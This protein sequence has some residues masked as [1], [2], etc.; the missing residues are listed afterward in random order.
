MDEIPADHII[1][2]GEQRNGLGLG[3]KG[4]RKLAFD[5]AEKYRIPHIFNKEKLLI[6]KQ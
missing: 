6:R 1:M 4:V 3:V 2:L 5:F